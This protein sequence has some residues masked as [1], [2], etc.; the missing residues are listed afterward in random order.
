MTQDVDTRA[1]TVPRTRAGSASQ[2]ATEPT[3]PAPA[4]SA[5]QEAA[6]TVLRAVPAAVKVHRSATAVTPGTVTCPEQVAAGA[7]RQLE[8]LA[9]GWAAGLPPERGRSESSGEIGGA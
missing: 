5:T 1:A 7:Q 6:D 9:G 2:A 4:T 3:L 8:R